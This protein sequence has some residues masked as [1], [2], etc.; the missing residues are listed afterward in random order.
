MQLYLFSNQSHRSTES[1]NP[2]SCSS[3]LTAGGNNPPFGN[4][5]PNQ[6]QQPQQP[7]GFGT[8]NN[9]AFATPGSNQF[10]FGGAP[11]AQPQPSNAPAGFAFGQQSAPAFPTPPTSSQLQGF[12]FGLTPQQQQPAGFTFGAPPPAQAQQQQIPAVGAFKFGGGQQQQQ[13]PPPLAPS[14][15]TFGGGQQ[16]K[17]PPAAPT[18]QP[19]PAAFTFGAKPKTEGVISQDNNSY[20]AQKAAALANMPTFAGTTS[21]SGTGFKTTSSPPQQLQQKPSTTG[22]G[23]LNPEELARRAQRAARFNRPTPVLDAQQQQQQRQEEHQAFRPAPVFAGNTGDSGIDN[24]KINNVEEDEDGMGS[25]TRMKKAI[26]GTCEDMCPAVERERRQAMSDIQIFER[27]NA[28]SANETSPE[29]AVKR[30]ARTV[31]DPSPSEFRTRGGLQRT[32]A[33][34]RNLLDQ[35]HFRFGLV[36]K[37]LWDRYRSVRQ[38]LYIQGMADGFAVGIFEEIVRFHV[39]CE[40]ELAGEDQSVTEVEGFNSHLN[41]EQANK[42]LISL[43][44]MYNKL[45]AAGHPQQS[46]A[47]FRAYHL[48]SLMASHGK[49]KGDQQA[50]LS[51]LNSLRLEVRKAPVIQ[52][53]LALQRAIGDNNYVRFFSLVKTAPYLIACAAHTYFPAVRKRALKSLADSMCPSSKVTAAV[54]LG[55]LMNLLLLDSYEEAKE[56]VTLYGYE[57]AEQDVD[58]GEG[59]SGMMGGA[60]TTDNRQLVAILTKH[61]YTEPPPPVARRPSAVITAKAPPTRAAAVLTPASQPLSKEELEQL[62]ERE[63]VMRAEAEV[64]RRAEMEIAARRAAE[65]ADAEAAAQRKMQEAEERARQVQL[66]EQQRV[67][68]EARMKEIA[69]QEEERRQREEEERCRREEEERQRREAEEQRQ[70]EEA[71]RRAAEA[72][73]LAAVEAERKRREAEKAERRRLVELERQ[74]LEELRRIEEEKQRVREAKRRLA[75]QKLYFARWVKEARRLAAERERQAKIAASF[76]ACRVGIKPSSSTS[77]TAAALSH[78]VQQQQAVDM[79]DLAA[80]LALRQLHL[81]DHPQSATL[82]SARHLQEES[83]RP[84]NLP[85]TVA[86]E[87]VRSNQ[88]AK[89]LFWKLLVVKTGASTFLPTSSTESSSTGDNK[90]EIAEKTGRNAAASVGRWLELVLSPSPSNNKSNT[91]VVSPSPCVELAYIQGPS[92]VSIEGMEYGSDSTR[93]GTELSTCVAFQKSSS[94]N[95]AKDAIAGAAAVVVVMGACPSSSI[96]QRHILDSMQSALPSNTG[97][98]YPIMVLVQNEG[99]ATDWSAAIDNWQTNDGDKAAVLFHAV[100]VGKGT[101]TTSC[102]A[103]SFDKKS[104]IV[105]LKWLAQHAPAQHALRVA[106]AEAVVRQALQATLLPLQPITTKS[107]NNTTIPPHYHYHYQAALTQALTIVRKTITLATEESEVSSWQWPPPEISTP[108]LQYWYSEGS[109]AELIAALDQVEREAQAALDTDKASAITATTHESLCLALFMSLS[110]LESPDLPAIVM[111]EDVYLSFQVAIDQAATSLPPPFID[112]GTYNNNNNNSGSRMLAIMGDGESPK[113]RKRDDWEEGWNASRVSYENIENNILNVA[114]TALRTGSALDQQLGWMSEGA[115]RNRVVY[116]NGGGSVVSRGLAELAAK[117]DTERNEQGVFQQHV[118]SSMLSSGDRGRGGGGGRDQIEE[119]EEG[120]G[121]IA[122]GG[123]GFLSAGLRRL[124]GLLQTE[125]KEQGKLTT[126]AWK[127][128]AV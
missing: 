23:G 126:E 59:G 97:F 95:I 60:T 88:Q 107:S 84:I 17:P 54:E 68:E 50:F 51:T 114:Y 80:E 32:M 46:E 117:L 75:I 11:P 62:A 39:L 104:L 125:K 110:P 67:A 58:T 119:K 53:V 89:N 30:F 45:A 90:Y 36:H 106:R 2:P 13:P 40:H 6:P 5:Q 43:S 101:S 100:G 42:A 56:L 49:F 8:L 12:G 111:P 121:T 112:N 123:G 16:H 63:R 66:V 28:N 18:P 20:K 47:E 27:V 122:S 33:H 73:R 44:E 34:L 35:S 120:E 15:F 41:M 74:R 92:A 108:P 3:H 64:K 70:K 9:N 87:L 81:H 78:E 83:R 25:P 94:G 14:G 55:W 57:V 22:G 86:E 1:H 19:P 72:A 115:F 103:S 31:D 128:S 48:I 69:Q 93:R 98:C 61:G 109:T 52:W 29:L 26:V 127:A 85:S 21:A 65:R 24:N 116:S 105:A 38:D 76:K 96:A 99:W 102:A 113:K 71:A 118:M 91:T 124:R 10:T 7:F 4:P 82:N 77:T 79:D 37:F